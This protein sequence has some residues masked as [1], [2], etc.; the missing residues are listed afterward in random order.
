MFLLLINMGFSQIPELV[1][2]VG[3]TGKIN[4]AFYSPD[5]KYIVTAST[6]KTAKV[7]E[8][9][10]GKLLYNLEGHTDNVYTAEFSSNR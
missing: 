2:P 7:W 8:I 5:G 9:K 3:H 4:S 6:D 1:L 10:S